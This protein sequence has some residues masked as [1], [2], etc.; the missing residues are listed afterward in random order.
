MF[1]GELQVLVRKIVAQKP[2]FKSKA[3]Q[4]LNNQYAQKLRDPYFR[5][6]ARGQCLSS[7]DSESF[8]QFQDWLALMS[9][10]GGNSKK[11]QI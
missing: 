4:A 6:I 3:N 9:I 2:E 8:T 10:A 7:L 5:V 1:A 11:K